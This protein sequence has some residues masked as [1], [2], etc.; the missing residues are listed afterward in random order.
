MSYFLFFFLVFRDRVSLYSPGCP[1]THFVDQAGL[2]LRNPPASASQVLGLKACV[3]T[4]GSMWTINMPNIQYISPWTQRSFK[5]LLAN[6]DM[7]GRSSYD[8]LEMISLWSQYKSQWL[9]RFSERKVQMSTWILEQY[10]CY[11]YNTTMMDMCH[12]IF[13]QAHATECPKSKVLCRV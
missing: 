8:S 6:G 9:W 3:T 10:Q 7:W 11:F 12:W 13:I 1:G 2:E 4:A 5:G